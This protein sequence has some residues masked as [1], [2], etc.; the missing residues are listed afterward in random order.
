MR[1]CTVI[2]V[3]T[4]A[5]LGACLVMF[6]AFA[7]TNFGLRH[8]SALSASEPSHAPAGW[9]MAGSKPANYGAGVDR[10]AVNND[11]PSAFLQ[12]TVSNTEGFGT[13]MQSISATDYVG[14]RVRLR[15]WVKSQDVADWAGIWMRVDKEQAAVAFDN[16]QNRA[17]KG[18]QS[19]NM[20]DVVL[21][22]PQ[23][24]TGISFGVLLSGTGEVWMNDLR[25]ENVGN[26]VPVTAPSPEGL[27]RPDHPVNLKF[28]E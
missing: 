20:Y 25:F 10:A 27:K 28:T 3:V 13:L 26:D 24:A 17:I 18:T 2:R 12:S 6:P 21:D 5:V 14:K 15:A 9:F 22:V 23:D 11:Q 8:V 1:L 7:T 16:M 4:S 19:W